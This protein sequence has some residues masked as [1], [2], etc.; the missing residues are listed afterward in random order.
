[1]CEASRDTRRRGRRRRPNLRSGED[2]TPVIAHVVK[3]H[4]IVCHRQDLAACFIRG[5]RVLDQAAI[6]PLT[7]LHAFHAT[8]KFYI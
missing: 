4:L 8:E 2:E 5:R 1:M 7:V 6:L 3:F